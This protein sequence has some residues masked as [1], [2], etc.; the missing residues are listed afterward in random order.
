MAN[1]KVEIIV[2][3]GHNYHLSVKGGRSFTSVDYNAYRYG[4]ASPCDNEVAVQNAIKG[5][6]KT[7]I[8]EGDVPVLIDSRNKATLNHWLK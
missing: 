2:S 6:E 7:I 8:N 4:G 5:A 3:E 1:K